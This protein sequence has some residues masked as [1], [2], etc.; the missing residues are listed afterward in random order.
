MHAEDE[1]QIS[2]E[3]N[4]VCLIPRN[5]YSFRKIASLGLRCRSP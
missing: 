4:L 3:Q 1:K 2:V 5:N